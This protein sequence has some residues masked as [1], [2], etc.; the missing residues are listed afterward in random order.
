MG[1]LF[2]LLACRAFDE[3]S[4]MGIVTWFKLREFKTW[5]HAEIGLWEDMLGSGG[6]TK[7]AQHLGGQQPFSLYGL[8]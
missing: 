4:K 8:F 1:D 7:G 2:Y 5:P 6:N 3:H